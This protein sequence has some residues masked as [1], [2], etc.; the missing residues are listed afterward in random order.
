VRESEGEANLVLE[1]AERKDRPQDAP[2]ARS[3]GA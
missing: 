3:H 1:L 2:S